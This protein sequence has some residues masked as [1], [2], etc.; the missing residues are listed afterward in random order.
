MNRNGDFIQSAKKQR[1]DFFFDGVETNKDKFA[2]FLS[3]VAGYGETAR[4]SLNVGRLNSYDENQLAFRNYSS[5]TMC[6]M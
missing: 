4:V 1:T 6:I 3:N 2:R 5:G